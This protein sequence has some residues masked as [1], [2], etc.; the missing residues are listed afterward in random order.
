VLGSGQK[1][2]DCLI[3]DG[4]L[5]VQDL[6]RGSSGVVPDAL[7]DERGLKR[8]VFAPLRFRSRL[9]LL[10]GWDLLVATMYPSAERH[11]LHLSCVGGMIRG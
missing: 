5:E 7:D 2:S 11:P 6:V 4:A 1:P 10:P 3:A 8:H 9:F